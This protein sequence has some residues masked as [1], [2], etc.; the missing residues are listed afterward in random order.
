MDKR[1]DATFEKACSEVT[2][3]V[4][5]TVIDIKNEQV[6]SLYMYTIIIISLN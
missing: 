1:C 4:C 6:K 3:N 2:E 5:A